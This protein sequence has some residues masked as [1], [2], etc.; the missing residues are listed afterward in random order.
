MTTVP[1]NFNKLLIFNI[2][3]R[4]IY[5]LSSCFRYKYTFFHSSF[6]TKNELTTPIKIIS[7]EIN[8]E[9]NKNI[10]HNFRCVQIKIMHL[11]Q[12][13]ISFYHCLMFQVKLL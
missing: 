11:L 5:T 13:Y 1:S 4:K 3:C 9:T 7:V 6:Y 12:K 8:Y 2:D 10:V